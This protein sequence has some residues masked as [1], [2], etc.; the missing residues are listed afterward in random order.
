MKTKIP[1]E[2]S[3]KNP[4]NDT[5]EPFKRPDG[6]VALDY[7][8]SRIKID[9]ETFSRMWRENHAKNPERWPLHMLEGD[10]DEQFSLFDEDAPECK[11]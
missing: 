11:E 2:G 4:H 8:V 5:L 7:F 3:I 6:T 10:W 1:V 9:I